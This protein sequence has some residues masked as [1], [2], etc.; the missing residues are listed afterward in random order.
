M[1]PLRLQL[2]HSVKDMQNSVGKV[3]FYTLKLVLVVFA[4]TN[5]NLT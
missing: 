2:N 1:S 3:E 4:S 5:F